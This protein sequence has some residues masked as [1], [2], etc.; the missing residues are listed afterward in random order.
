MLPQKSRTHKRGSQSPIHKQIGRRLSQLAAISNDNWL[1]RG[2]V[3]RSNSFNLLHDVHAL[4]HAAKDNVLSVQPWGRNGAEEEL[5]AVGVWSCI[6]HRQN[7]WANVLLSEVL[8]S[9]LLAINGLATRAIA[10]GEVSSLAHEFRNHSV[11]AGALEVQRLARLAFSFL[12][13][14]ERTEVFASLG[15]NVAVK[16]HDNAAGF[17]A[18]NRNIEENFGLGHRGRRKV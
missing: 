14:A 8:V 16:G 17:D 11:K 6:G 13:S 10:L 2:T 15:A 3:G 9:E 18:T 5:A 4:S 1:G 12:A 7:A